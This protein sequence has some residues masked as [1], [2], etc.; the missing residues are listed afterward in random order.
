VIVSWSRARSRVDSRLY[1]IAPAR[2]DLLE[3]VEAA[4]R[5]GVDIVQVR[6]KAMPDGELLSLLQRVRELTRRLGIP[7]VVNDRPDLA[8]L[9]EADFVHI[10]QDDLPVAAARRLGLE[11]G[12]STHAPAEIDGASGDYIGVGPVNATPTK[13]GRPA[14][15]LELVRYAA[16]HARRP[17]F[18]IGGIDAENVAEVVAAGA[19]RVAVVRAI[20]GADDPERAAAALRSALP[21]R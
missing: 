18:A 6:E 12:E 16:E 10:G 3:L 20:C 5:G 8:L 17:W 13:E 15:G 4:V 9:A 21:G 11:V 19:Q 7:F 2:P 14:V 1:L